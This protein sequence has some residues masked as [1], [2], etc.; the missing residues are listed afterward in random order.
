MRPLIARALRVARWHHSPCLFSRRARAR[1]YSLIVEGLNHRLGL[2]CKGNTSM[3]CAMLAL[4]ERNITLAQASAIPEDDTWRYDADPATGFKG[5]FS[6][7]CSAFVANAYKVALE[8]VLPR[9]NSHEFTP[10]DVYQLR[11]FDTGGGGGGGSDGNGGSGGGGG[12]FNKTNCPV[13]LL[14]SPGGGSYCQLMGPY[15]L[16]LNG[17]NTVAPYA[18]MNDHC[19]AQW[20]DYT[21]TRP[22]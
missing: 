16:P 13:G 18:G 10:K 19:T 12:R 8:A 3:H 22:C 2:K 6:M 14:Q 4:S 21:T 20:P 17:Y 7:M 15:R 5:N 9:F 11:I 1:R